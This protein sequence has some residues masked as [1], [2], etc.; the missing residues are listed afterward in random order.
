MLLGCTSSWFDY[1]T[2]DGNNANPESDINVC[3]VDLFG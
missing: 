2:A 1:S 3:Y